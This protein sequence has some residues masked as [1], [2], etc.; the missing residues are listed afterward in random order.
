M[1]R[2]RGFN[3]LYF[4]HMKS[5]CTPVE[6]DYRWIADWGF[7][8]V[9]LPSCYTLWTEGED[10]YQIKEATLEKLDNAIELAAKY[11]LHTSL[12]LH[13]APGYSVNRERKEPFDL[14]KDQ[15]A[16]DAFC[17]HWQMF[18][19]RYKGISADALSFDLVNEPPG[20]RDDGMTRSDH[21]RVA[22]ATVAKIR[23]INPDRLIVADGLSWGNDPC[24]EL[25]DLAIGQSCRGYRPMTV[26]HYM[27]S[28]VKSENFPFPTW[29][30]TE[31]NG[32]TWDK[33]R[34]EQHYAGWFDL[35]EKGVGVHCGECGCYNK[36]PH[37]VFLSWFED[38]LAIL[39][40]KNVGYA[41]WNF[42]GSFGILDSQREDVDYQDWH[43]RKLDTKLLELLRRY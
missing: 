33:Q 18:A 11:N 39:T 7:D 31:R 8:F 26:S 41:L 25:A 17:F 9:R 15:E 27:A 28:W 34:L 12:N 3:L 40:E 24:P 36:T 5:D 1:P 16:L 21:E 29:P 38:V 20:P 13:R 23:E 6:D 42:R 4:F 22:R 32:E 30:A 10:P 14:W 2:W 43:G 37:E 35:I 19:K